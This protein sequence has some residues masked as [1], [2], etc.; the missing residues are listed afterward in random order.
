MRKIRKFLSSSH[1]ES[2]FHFRVFVRFEVK[3]R[4]SFLGFTSCFREK[5]RGR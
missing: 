4:K 2:T 3:I 1:R 5:G